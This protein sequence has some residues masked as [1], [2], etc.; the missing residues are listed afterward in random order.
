[1]RSQ[2][3]SAEQITRAAGATCADNYQTLTE[4]TTAYADLRAAVAG[5]SISSDN[6]F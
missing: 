5:L 3:F 1:M 6:P 2:G 4:K